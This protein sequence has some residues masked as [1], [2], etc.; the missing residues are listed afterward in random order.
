M[1]RRSIYKTPAQLRAMVEPGLITAAALDAVR[2]L[3][4]PGVT[5]LEL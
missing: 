5:T 1:L 4:A 2:A 3:A